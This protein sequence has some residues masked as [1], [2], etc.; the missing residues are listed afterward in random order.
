MT[1]ITEKDRLGSLLK[2]ELDK[3]Y[4][5][6]VVTIASGQNL[7]MGTVLGISASGKYT[8]SVTNI[9]EDGESEEVRIPAKAV[10]LEDCDASTADKNALVVMRTAIVAENALIFPEDA[11]SDDKVQYKKDLES[12][13]IVCRATA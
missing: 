2:Y 12:C 10:L 4:C 11:T 6:E 9:I 5:R 3:N 1:A 13:G 8:A 7:S